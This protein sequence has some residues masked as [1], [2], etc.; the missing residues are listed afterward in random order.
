MAR[1][2]AYAG[3]GY[4][5]PFLELTPENPMLIE[6]TDPVTLH[7]NCGT[8]EAAR[9]RE[10]PSWKLMTRAVQEDCIHSIRAWVKRF[11]DLV[12]A[13]LDSRGRTAVH[14]AAM[15]NAKHVLE[16]LLDHGGNLHWIDRD[17]NTP[18]HLCPPS[19]AMAPALLLL[20]GANA[21]ALNADGQPPAHP[22][23]VNHRAQ[24]SR[25]RS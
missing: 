1:H 24:H 4:D 15:H 16:F 2:I 13:A 22:L 8:Y 18:L 12:H 20:R 10:L 6:R 11:P 17:G 19:S 3:Y 7:C 9:H 14:Y 21:Y 5:S 23:A 25:R